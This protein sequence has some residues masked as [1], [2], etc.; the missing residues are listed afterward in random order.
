MSKT[1]ILWSLAVVAAFVGGFAASRLVHHPLSLESELNTHYCRCIEERP[2]YYPH[3][4]DA[5]SKVQEQLN[6]E[7]ATFA[8]THGLT[9][10]DFH[11]IFVPCSNGNYEMYFH[12]THRNRKTT[13]LLQTYKDRMYNCLEPYRRIV[14]EA[15][16]DH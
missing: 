4:L 13:E 7:S 11:A 2:E 16:G 3:L 6:K 8:K 15:H 5:A 12:C 14:R 9:E 10:D 1:S